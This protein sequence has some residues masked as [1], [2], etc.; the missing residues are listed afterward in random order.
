MMTLAS[1][2][3]E[4]STRNFTAGAETLGDELEQRGQPEEADQREHEAEDAGR[5]VVDEHLEAGLDLAVPDLVDLLDEVRTERTT[6]HRAEDHDRA[7]GAD[8]DA[9][10]HHGT[11]DG[12]AGLVD[13]PAALEGD[14]ERDE[15]GQDRADEADVGHAV[16]LTETTEDAHG[17]PTGLDEEGGDE[18]PRDEDRDVGHHHAG[19]ERAELLDGDASATPRLVAGVWRCNGRR[20]HVR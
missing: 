18:A 20:C 11:D 15:V 14:R 2:S 3:S 6:D 4:L 8:D 12:A 5:V 9:H 1:G 13:H 19:Q 17:R 7:V 10:G 16:R